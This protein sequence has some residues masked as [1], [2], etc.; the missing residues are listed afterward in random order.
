MNG[1]S[2]ITRS[3]GESVNPVNPGLGSLPG[4]L[5]CALYRITL[6]VFYAHFYLGHQETQLNLEPS[7]NPR[8]WT[9]HI[10]KWQ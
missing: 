1:I 9:L 5:I 8:H 10:L 2:T 6:I 7:C 4:G 3:Q